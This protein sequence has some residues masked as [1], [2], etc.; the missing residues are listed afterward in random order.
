[1]AGATAAIVASIL[2]CLDPN[3]MG[4]AALVKNDIAFSLAMFAFAAAVWRLG[5]GITPMRVLTVCITLAAGL[6]T[7]FSGVLLPGMLLL[8]LGAYALIHQRRQ[9]VKIGAVFVASIAFSLLAIW[10]IYGFRFAPS[11]TGE[12]FNVN[13][14][15]MALAL[16]REVSEHGMQPTNEALVARIRRPGTVA[17]TLLYANDHHLLPQA[18]VMGLMYT[19]SSSLARPG[20]LL[21]EIRSTGWWYYFPLAWM[22]K[23]PVSAIVAVG[24]GAGAAIRR[25]ARVRRLSKEKQWTLAAFGIPVV[26][27]GAFAMTSHLNIGLRHIFPLYPF[28]FLAAS[29][30]IARMRVPYGVVIAFAVVLF[31]ETASGYPELIS[32]FNLPSRL[33]GPIHLLGDSNIDWG[34]NLP[35]LEGWQRAHADDVL[36]LDYFGTTPPEYYGIVARTVPAKWEGSG[37]VALSATAALQGIYSTPEQRERYAEFRR[38]RPLAIAGGTLYL[39]LRP[40][41]R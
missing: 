39:Y 3:L 6:T 31:I 22:F 33:A 9:I 10:A 14:F 35:Q 30:A 21:G 7:K 4:H 17:S 13:Y 28:M 37:V 12:Q 16:N 40:A 26:V 29:V 36:Y 27:Y 11:P 5:K 38:R 1:M 24:L 15:R 41:L 19:Y 8:M 18:W 32:Y 25:A 34:Q 23:S 2:Y 20:F